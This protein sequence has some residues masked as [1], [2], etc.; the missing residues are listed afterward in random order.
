MAVI[1]VPAEGAAQLTS[2]TGT[3][4]TVTTRQLQLVYRGME[5]TTSSRCALNIM[6]LGVLFGEPGVR[7]KKKSLFVLF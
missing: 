4:D 3:S 2:L 1:A 5:T 6:V 7:F